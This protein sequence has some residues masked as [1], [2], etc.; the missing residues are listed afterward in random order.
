MPK[1]L[2]PDDL[3]P[4]MFVTVL[5][6]HRPETPP[7]P[8]MESPI[9]AAISLLAVGNRVEEY[10]GNL[11]GEPLEV[12]AVELPFLMV[13]NLERPSRPTFSIDTRRCDLME[14][15][16]VYARSPFR[17]WWQFWRGR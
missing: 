10:Y 1:V 14:V 17:R 2:P 5:K 12:R 9:G 3:R 15:G 13:R 4:G 6:G 8:E 11:K 16:R 7:T